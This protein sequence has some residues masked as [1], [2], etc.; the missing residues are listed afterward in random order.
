MPGL[1]DSIARLS[2][3][4]AID[5]A[6]SFRSTA[7]RLAPLTDFGSNPGQLLAKTFVPDTLPAKASLVVVLHGCTQT[8]EG[9]DRGSGWSQLAE[10]HGFA[11]IYPEQQRSNNANLCFNW[12]EPGDVRRGAGEVL[13]IRQMVAAMVDA[14][15]IDTTRVFVTGLS[16]GGAMTSALLACY[17]ETFAGG[18][19]IAGLPFGS[20]SNIAQALK[21]MRAA[22]GADAQ[23]LSAK[24]AAAS[25][26]NGPWPTVSVWHGEADTTVD[27]SNAIAIVEQWR[28]L[29]G[30]G[31][32]PTLSETVGE[33]SRRTWRSADGRDVIEL[34]AV[35]RMGH[36]TPLAANGPDACGVPGPHMLEAAVSSTRHIA[37]FWGLETRQPEAMEVRVGVATPPQLPTPQASASR[38]VPSLASGSAKIIEDALRAAGLMR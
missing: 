27:L 8:A 25:P 30:V 9:Y 26:H 16:A 31:S 4:R 36:G 21:R 11:L 37:R 35:K 34:W 22:G 29:H 5:M 23:V 13:S 33:H 3:R 20:A 6:S 15:D 28:D 7:G 2:K 18:A 10:K 32:A 19:V 14:H 24:V 12:F 38:L 17:P 1:A